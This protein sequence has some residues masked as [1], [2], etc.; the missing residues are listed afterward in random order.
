MFNTKYDTTSK[1]RIAARQEQTAMRSS[2]NIQTKSYVESIEPDMSYKGYEGI[3]RAITESYDNAN[4]VN[5][6]IRKWDRESKRM[7]ILSMSESVIENFNEASASSAARIVQGT[8]QRFYAKIRGLMQNYMQDIKKWMDKR[9]IADFKRQVKNID[10]EACKKKTLD[11]YEAPINPEKLLADLNFLAIQGATINYTDND[12]SKEDVN[13]QNQDKANLEKRKQEIENQLKTAQGEAKTKLNNERT[14][15]EGKLNNMDSNVAAKDTSSTRQ[16]NVDTGSVDNTDLLDKM[17][18]QL[19]GDDKASLSDLSEKY[20]RKCYNPEQT[21]INIDPDTMFKPLE[22][23]AEILKNFSQQES[24]FKKIADDTIKKAKNI[25]FRDSSEII[26]RLNNNCSAM[27]SLCY[28]MSGCMFKEV[29]FGLN[30]ANSIFQLAMGSAVSINLKTGNA[31]NNQQQKDDGTVSNKLDGELGN[32]LNVE[33]KKLMDNGKTLNEIKYTDLS[34]DLK[35][36]I[37]EGE[38]KTAI[39]MV[40]S[41]IIGNNGQ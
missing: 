10:R 37:N 15:I 1:K 23:G 33:V 11:G 36:R 24:Q 30:Q 21:N 8:M 2:N 40:K 19:L 31:N 18:Q 27:C 22:H 9:K 32:K 26:K 16:Y 4:I 25:K 29:Q 14:E 13:V 3:I 39:E 17:V 5:E 7:E 20:H 12:T 38:F 6:Y 34:E 41:D 28:Q 35:K